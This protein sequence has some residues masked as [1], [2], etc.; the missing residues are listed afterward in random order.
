MHLNSAGEAY[1]GPWLESKHNCQLIMNEKRKGKI[2]ITKV[3][4][5]PHRKAKELQ[6]RN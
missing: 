1:R 5:N 2:T 6:E 3:I 4:F